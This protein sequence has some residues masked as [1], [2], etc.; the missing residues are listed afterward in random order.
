[1][2][3]FYI[4]AIHFSDMTKPIRSIELMNENELLNTAA[5]IEK[6][7]KNSMAISK[8]KSRRIGNKKNVLNVL[9]EEFLKI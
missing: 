5:K 7:L 4:R 1:M 2:N 8:V 6:A 9:Y 3:I